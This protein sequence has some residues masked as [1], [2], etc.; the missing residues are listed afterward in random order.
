MNVREYLP[1]GKYLVLV[2]LSILL[3]TPFLAYAQGVPPIGVTKSNRNPLQIA[4]LHWYDANL[5]ASFPTGNTPGPIAFDGANMWVANN[6]DNNV[7]K[8]RASDGA[9]LGTFGVSITSPQ[10][11][12]FDGAN[13]WVSNGSSNANGI[14]TKLRASDGTVQGTFT[15]IAGAYGVAFDG[16]NIWVTNDDPNNP[17]VNKL[18]A[19]DGT[20]LGSFPVGLSPPRSD[21]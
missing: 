5:A 17:L 20:M 19:S 2:L 14:V 3:V 11:L 16:S 6:H 8:I 15:S 9:L 18:R 4:I 7:Y 10:G 12:A 1:K 13:I 21:L